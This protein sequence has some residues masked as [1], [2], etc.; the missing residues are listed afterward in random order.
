M[1]VLFDQ[2]AFANSTLTRFYWKVTINES[3]GFDDVT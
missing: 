1:I 2:F 3:K